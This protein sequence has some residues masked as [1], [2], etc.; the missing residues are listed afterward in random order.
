[1]WAKHV[2]V[3]EAA[4]VPSLFTQGRTRHAGHGGRDE[5]HARTR[6][7]ESTHTRERKHVTIG[8][9]LSRHASHAVVVPSPLGF[10][11]VGARQGGGARSRTEDGS[12]YLLLLARC[13]K[14]SDA[15]SSDASGSGSG[16][17]GSGAGMWPVR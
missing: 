7:H 5:T 6:H 13:T 14:S 3:A 8:Q 4:A 10:A 15:K 17:E 11:I 12:R 2:A 9:N 16:A 1:M